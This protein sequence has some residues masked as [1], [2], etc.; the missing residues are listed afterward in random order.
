MRAVAKER[1][2]DDQFDLNLTPAKILVI[3]GILADV[4]EVSSVLVEKNQAVQIVL[5]GSLRRKTT[6]DKM[7]DEMGKLSFDEVLEA[8]G[9]R[10]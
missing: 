1:F 4:L 7:L 8:L 5:S 9:R 10:L 6:L 3:I 2:C